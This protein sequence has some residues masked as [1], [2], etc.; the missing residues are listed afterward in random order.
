MSTKKGGWN[1]TSKISWPLNQNQVSPPIGGRSSATARNTHPVGGG[2]SIR[3]WRSAKS[4]EAG[5]LCH[6]L[7]LSLGNTWGTEPPFPPSTPLLSLA[8]LSLTD[9]AIA[10]SAS[11]KFMCAAVSCWSGKLLGDLLPGP[12][13]TVTVGDQHWW[14]NLAGAQWFY[15]GPG[16][17][18]HEMTRLMWI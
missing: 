16:F 17:C 18:S 14:A 15:L 7:L 2:S 13:L 3:S 9:S 1:G 8:L 11:F 12:N 6:L 4:A 10:P 5:Y